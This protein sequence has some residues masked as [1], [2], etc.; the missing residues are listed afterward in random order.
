[1]KNLKQ[2][3]YK[4]QHSFPGPQDTGA[5]A[6]LGLVITLRLIQFVELGT[7]SPPQYLF[8]SAH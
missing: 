7:I 1:M 5:G 2:T 6:G 4:Y 8:A 3:Y